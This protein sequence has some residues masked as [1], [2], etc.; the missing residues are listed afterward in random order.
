[1]YVGSNGDLDFGVGTMIG[2]SSAVDD[3]QWHLA[4]G[5]LSPTSMSLYLDG[6]LVGTTASA[7]S[8]PPYAGYWR[9][10]EV[11]GAYWT[12]TDGN[13]DPFTGDLADAAL[14][15]TVLTAGQVSALSAGLE[16]QSVSFTSTVPASAEVGSTYA[17]TA[18]ASSGLTVSITVDSSSS[19]IC[20]ISDGVV[21]FNAAGTCLLDATQG[22]NSSYYVAHEVHQIVLV[23]SI[24]GLSPTAFWP[25]SDTGGTT[26][27]DLSGSDDFGS[28]QGGVTEDVSAGSGGPSP[29]QV[30]GFDGSTGYISTASSVEG[31]DVYS[32]AGWFK[33]TSDN[34][35][36]IIQFG[37]DQTGTG[38][39]YDRQL[40]V[41]T[42]GNLYFG[43]YCGGATVLATSAPVDT[44]QWD[45]AVGVSTGSTMKLYLNGILVASNDFSECYDAAGYWRI[46]GGGLSGWTNEGSS[47]FD[48]DLAEVAVFP[49]ALTTGQV[50]ALYAVADGDVQTISFTSAA[51]LDKAVDDT[52]TPTAT[53]T[54]GL[55]G[56]LL[57]RLDQYLRMLDRGRHRHL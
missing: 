29:V 50:R 36:I 47:W 45:Y 28:L 34:G 18:T 6:S 17:P 14:F 54:S 46:G 12:N 35:G 2:T 51:P 11:D 24:F 5:T 20:S 25:L 40:Y 39:G 19:S 30:M 56:D 7:G 49:S 3:G 27:A 38:G 9:V 57:D 48:G 43:E 13:M 4:V 33:T 22:G 21:T 55:S 52:Y 23:G 42:D 15:P 31:P 16:W 37:Q 53:S 8:P 1:M 32:I 26:A 41:G 10:G 44:G